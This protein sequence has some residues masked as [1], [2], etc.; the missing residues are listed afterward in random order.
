MLYV[1]KIMNAP[2]DN[3]LFLLVNKKRIHSLPRP[4][5]RYVSANPTK[6]GLKLLIHSQ[7]IK[8]ATAEVSE[9]I[10]KFHYTL[11]WKCDYQSI[12]VIK[13]IC[14]SKRGPWAQGGAYLIWTDFIPHALHMQLNMTVADVLVPK[15][16]PYTHRSIIRIRW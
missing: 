14:V 13:L 1:A 16:T 7:N 10:S 2:A 12:S 9:W 3:S 6:Y 5:L 8:G 15:P 11:G 4:L